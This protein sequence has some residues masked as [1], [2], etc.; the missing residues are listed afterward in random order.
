MDGERTEVDR[1]WTWSITLAL[2]F[3]VAVSVLEFSLMV[4][5][6]EC[7]VWEAA[8]VPNLPDT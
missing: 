1:P 5:R 3:T 6:I 4:G 8:L 7:E 2:L